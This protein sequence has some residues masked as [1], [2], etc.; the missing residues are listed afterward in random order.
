[1]NTNFVHR[2]LTGV[3][4]YSGRRYFVTASAGIT[5]NT[6]AQ[7]VHRK[8]SWL[9]RHLSCVCA[10]RAGVPLEDRPQKSLPRLTIY[11]QRAGRFL[12]VNCRPGETFLLGRGDPIMGRLLWGRR[13]FNKGR[14]QIRDY[15][16]AGGSFY[17]ETF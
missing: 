16:F 14:H 17:G 11:W 12:P 2:R 10:H 6:A 8:E 1:M 4:A 15:L 7:Q 5:R 3:E 13:Y 9:N